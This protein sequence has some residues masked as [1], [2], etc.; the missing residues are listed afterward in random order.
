MFVVHHK[1]PKSAMSKIV[2]RSD[3][4]VE[5]ARDLGGDCGRAVVLDPAAFLNGAE[6]GDLV[7]TALP[8]AKVLQ[9][10]LWQ[11]HCHHCFATAPAKLSRCGRCRAV[12]YCA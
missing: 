12:Y 8:F 7:L 9:P 6:P 4:D 11:S 10:E 1:T 3:L 5:H 2:K